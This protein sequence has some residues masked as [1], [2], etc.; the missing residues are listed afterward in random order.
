MDKTYR[1]P[2]TAPADIEAV[3]AVV[4]E[5]GE[6]HHVATR[7]RTATKATREV[8]SNNSANS[9]NSRQS[10]LHPRRRHSMP[11]PATEV[12]V[13]VRAARKSVGLLISAFGGVTTD[14]AGGPACLK[15]EMDGNGM[16]D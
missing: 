9:S 3:E 16:Y 10:A 15:L 8:A 7:T 13:H 14:D 6:E 5:A 11:T 12:V 1:T 4:E 2:P